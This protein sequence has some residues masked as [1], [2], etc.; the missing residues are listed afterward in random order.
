[1]RKT[2]DQSRFAGG[3]RG[4]IIQNRLPCTPQGDEKQEKKTGKE[5]II[6]RETGET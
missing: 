3:G 2:L 6:Y 1:M 4:G 5:T